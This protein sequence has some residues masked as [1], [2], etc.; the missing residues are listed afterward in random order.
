MICSDKPNMS[1]AVKILDF[2]LAKIKSGELLGSFIQAQTTGLMGSPYYMAPEQ[3]ADEEPD[4]RADVYSL[5]VMF[6]QIMAGDVPFKGSSI[7]AIMKKHISDPAPTLADAGLKVPPSLELAIAHAL[8]KDAAKRT[9]TVEAFVAELTAAIYPTS[10]MSVNTGGAT[11]PTVPVS[12]LRVV[13]KPAKSRVFVDDVAIGETKD[14]GVLLVEGMQ[15]GNHFLRISHHGFEDWHA[16]VV[17][18]GTP[19]EVVAE[20]RNSGYNSNSAIPRPDPSVTGSGVSPL[21]Q[22][23]QQNL[24]TQVISSHNV[25]AAPARKGVSPLILGIGGLFAL[26]LLVVLGVGGA[27]MLRMMDSSAN[28]GNSE[29]ATPEPTPATGGDLK[30]Q[31]S[32]IDIPGGMFKM[33]NDNGPDNEQPEHEVRVKPFKMDKIEVTN[34]E[35]LEFI[36]ATGYKP[37]AADKFLAHW[38][39][40]KPIVGQ[41]LMPVRFVNV[42]D[43]T[44][45][46]EWRSKRDGVKYR[47]PTEQE[48]EFAARNGEDGNKFPWGESF[49]SECAVLDQPSTEPKAAGSQSCPN[50][51]GVVDLIGNVFEWTST[52]AGLY[53]GS[54]GLVKEPKDPKAMIRGGGAFSKS[55]GSDAVNSTFRVDVETRT[56]DKELGFRLVVEP[57]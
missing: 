16:D 26:L 24:A 19:Q 28:A 44:A 17:L 22:T 38:V 43:A 46:A 10:H 47:L 27:Y 5:G 20:L 30:V 51:W 11:M 3:W 45:F 31:A 29:S 34:A 57:N 25:A 6:Y 49:R 37:A 53:P 56:R 8:Q 55:S 54:P 36:T 13:S 7:P 12:S 39:N 35:Y 9:P 33:G 18:D 32:L 2:G 42:E 23:I 50:K 15:S 4:M 48:W 21:D 14:N 52:K 41:E 40:G 1:Q